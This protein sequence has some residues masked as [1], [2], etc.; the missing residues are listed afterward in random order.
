MANNL[1]VIIEKADIP[2]DMDQVFCDGVDF[3]IGQDDELQHLLLDI[4]L[5]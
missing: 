5:I 3:E 1:D 4:K 2:I